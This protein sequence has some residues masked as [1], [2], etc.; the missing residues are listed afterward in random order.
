MVKSY[1]NKFVLTCDICGEDAKEEHDT[2]K[3]AI[4]SQI[5][6]GFSSK[7]VEGIW[8]NVCKKCENE[9]ISIK[10]RD[11]TDVLH[12]EIEDILKNRHGYKTDIR[13]PECDGILVVR[14]SSTSFLGCSNYPSCRCLIGFKQSGMPRM[15][16]T[17][18]Y[19]WNKNL[20]TMDES[21]SDFMGDMYGSGIN[22]AD[23]M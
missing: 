11:Y 17:T 21:Y 13:C 9:E 20:F 6:N 16:E 12:Q 7:Q 5:D 18:S 19:M 10:K 23:D 15:Q 3:D 8:F 14:H 2:W 22:C 1:N 4:S